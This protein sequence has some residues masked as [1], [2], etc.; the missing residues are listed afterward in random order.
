MHEVGDDAADTDLDAE[1]PVDRRSKC[2]L[3]DNDDCDGYPSGSE[4]W[5][6]RVGER[7]RNFTLYD[8]NGVEREL[9]ELLREQDGPVCACY[10]GA[11]LIDF[12]AGYCESC[13]EE[14]VEIALVHHEWRKKG[15]RVLNVIVGD[16]VWGDASEGLCAAWANGEFGDEI[17]LEEEVPLPFPV[18]FGM[19]T[20]VADFKP[21]DVSWSEGDQVDPGLPLRVLLDANANIREIPQG[22]L[23]KGQLE[24]RLMTILDDPFWQDR[25]M[26]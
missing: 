19:E 25:E 3:Q 7:L 18:W 16:D 21:L 4:G 10:D 9:A 22:D 8:C 2:L 12:G 20:D 26:E 15:V 24:E 13:M 1:C 23:P 17:D 11:I 6:H 5:G 14:S